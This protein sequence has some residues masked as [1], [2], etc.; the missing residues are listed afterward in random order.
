[1]PEFAGYLTD[2]EIAEVLAALLEAR[3][4]SPSA[5][6][7][8]MAGLDLGY[9]GLLP[10]GT[11]PS[12]RQR[13]QVT[14]MNR[15][16]NL[17]NGDV[18]LAQYLAAAVS[19]AGPLPA[20]DR[21]ESALAKVNAVRTGSR[22]TAPTSVPAVATPGINLDVRPEAYTRG[23]DGTLGV[24][25]LR[26]GMNAAASVVKLLVHRHVN[27]APE[28]GAGDIPQ[29]TSGT[30]WIIGPNLMITNYHVINAREDLAESNEGDASEGDFL[31]QA[32]NTSVLYDYVDR[33]SQPVSYK[34]GS[35]ALVYFNKALDFAILRV[36]AGAPGRPPLRL[37]KQLIRKTP[38]Q[39]LDICVNV[40]QHPNGDPMRLGF[41]DNFVVL[42]DEETLSYLTD[43]SFGSS[44]SPVCDDHWTV[45]AL[46]SGSRS[47]S[48]QNIEIRGT[49]LRREN[50][51]TPV[52][53]LL[54]RLQND[55][56]A[57]HEAIQTGQDQD[58]APGAQVSQ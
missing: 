29:L 4:A 10:T 54:A 42:G 20:A 32:E 1:M 38:V 9:V 27:G 55:H 16:P 40:L 49:K 34:A 8:L 28:F 53:T 39:P 24:R 36:P 58:D 44:G 6:D 33:Q 48:A 37:R 3:L 56:P 5:Q 43:T 17:R 51:G 31:L 47:I 26:E 21:L 14:L 2:T 46:H 11:T 12:V 13:T 18:P 35:G 22:V 45:A 23:I 50:F 19:L 25:F 15:V 30:G 41:R 7:A 57:V 52:P